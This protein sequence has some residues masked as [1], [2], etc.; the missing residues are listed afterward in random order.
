MQAIVDFLFE[1]KTQET[2]ETQRDP[3]GENEG[4]DRA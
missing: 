2:R 1:E 3:D 4:H